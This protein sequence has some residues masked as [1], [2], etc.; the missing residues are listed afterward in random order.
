MTSKSRRTNEQAFQGV[1]IGDLTKLFG[2]RYGNGRHINSQTMMR[3][4]KICASFSTTMRM[5]IPQR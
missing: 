4:A 5:Q 3:A 2:H 1:R